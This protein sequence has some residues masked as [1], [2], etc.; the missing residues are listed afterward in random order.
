MIAALWVL[1]SATWAG[2]VGALFLP[3][4]FVMD[5]LM[6]QVTLAHGIIFMAALIPQMYLVPWAWRDCAAQGFE[7][8]VRKRWRVGFF[9]TGFLAVTWYLVARPRATSL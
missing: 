6:G 3:A 1:L 7:D 4:T 9:L 5:L 2:H 8:D